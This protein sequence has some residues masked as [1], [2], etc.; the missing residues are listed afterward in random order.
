MHY[1]I[2]YKGNLQWWDRGTYMYASKSS[3][4]RALRKL[5]KELGAGGFRVVAANHR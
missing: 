2:Q 4:V 3:A 1:K 5:E